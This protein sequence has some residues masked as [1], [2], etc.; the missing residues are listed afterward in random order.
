MGAQASNQPWPGLL[1]G[2]GLL[3]PALPVGPSLAQPLLAT[4]EPPPPPL[5]LLL[6]LLP[7]AE[8]AGAGGAGAA[9]ELGSEA[10]GGAALEEALALA[11]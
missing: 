10:E 1:R 6:L 9:A 5:L 3:L 8:G 4:T 7:P 11:L 2:T